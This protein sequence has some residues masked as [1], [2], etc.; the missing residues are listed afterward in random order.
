ML[1]N[2]GVSVPEFGNTYSDA[3]RMLENGDDV[4]VR[5]TLTGHS[6]QGIEL[7]RASEWQFIPDAPLYVQYIKKQ[8]EYRVHVGRFDE[9]NGSPVPCYLALDV[10][11]KMKRRSHPNE[12]TNYQ[13]RNHGTG[14]IYARDSIDA[15]SMVM[16]E[17]IKA[18]RALG[19]DFGAVDIVFNEHQQK[20]FV[21]EINT[22]CGLEGTTLDTYIK[23]FNTY[24]D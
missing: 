18:V 24:I 23:Y 19:L 11:K 21:L 22:A 7:L 8:D 1:K 16:F 20:A 9:R 6:G 5:H 3:L 15:P 14:W 12:D 17:A 2:K 13:V 4:M 10:Q